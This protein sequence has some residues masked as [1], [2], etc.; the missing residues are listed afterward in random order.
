[1]LQ[2]VFWY[3]NDKDLKGKWPPQVTNLNQTPNPPQPRSP[4]QKKNW[5]W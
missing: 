4:P 3:G 2:G 1:M 5:Y